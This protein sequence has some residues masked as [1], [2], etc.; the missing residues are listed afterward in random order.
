MISPDRLVEG[1]GGVTPGMALHPLKAP[2]RFAKSPLAMRDNHDPWPARQYVDF[3]G[4]GV[5]KLALR[6]P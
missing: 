1:A 5:G 3:N 2:G 4:V 6:A